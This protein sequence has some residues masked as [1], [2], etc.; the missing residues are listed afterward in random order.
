MKVLTSNVEKEQLDLLESEGLLGDDQDEAPSPPGPVG[1]SA[2]ADGPSMFNMSASAKLAHQLKG[3]KVI[4]N[5]T[6]YV[7]SSVEH[8][9]NLAGVDKVRESTTPYCPE[10][11]LHPDNDTAKGELGSSAC[12]IRVAMSV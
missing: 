12:S 4:F 7:K 9:K 10:G 8:Y 5:M 11:S 3:R 2:D 1:V 6:D